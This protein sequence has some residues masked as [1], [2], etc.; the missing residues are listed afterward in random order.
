MDNLYVPLRSGSPDDFCLPYRLN[1][2]GKNPDNH[3]EH[4]Q[5]VSHGR[6]Y[7]GGMVSRD[8]GGQVSY[9]TRSNEA[10][11]YEPLTLLS[12]ASVLYNVDNCTLQ[13][14]EADCISVHQKEHLGISNA[15]N[16]WSRAK[17]TREK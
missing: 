15:T 4:K 6:Y 17:K 2:Q 1:P 8:N 3:E 10:P 13:G 12:G 11:R 7:T 14:A 9:V 5:L 16:S